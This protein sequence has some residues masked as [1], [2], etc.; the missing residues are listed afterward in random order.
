MSLPTTE[1][2]LSGMVSRS[3][4]SSLESPIPQDSVVF[5][6][7]QSVRPP[8]CAYGQRWSVSLDLEKTL[9][10]VLDHL[11]ERGE[12]WPLRVQNERSVTNSRLD[13]P[14]A[15]CTFSVSSLS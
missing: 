4:S 8:L 14:Y 15:L 6:Q 10:H 9:A 5:I 1:R 13:G 7:S 12:V 11:P 2:F 3:P